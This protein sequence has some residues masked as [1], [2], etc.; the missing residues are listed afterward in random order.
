MT[1]PRT[2]HAIGCATWRSNNVEVCDCLNHGEPCTTP[3]RWQHRRMHALWRSAEITDR[4]DRLALTGAIV[5]RRLSTSNALTMAEA[6]RV[7]E[8]LT[9]KD[10][11]GL[12]A[13]AAARWL[14]E[15]RPVA[16]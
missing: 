8:Y 10:N 9:G 2:D 13:E 5:G 3:T 1:E 14:A 12:L 15:H 6:D 7:I 4:A 11:A 16:S